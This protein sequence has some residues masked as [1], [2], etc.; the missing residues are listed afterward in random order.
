MKAFRQSGDDDL[1]HWSRVSQSPP[2]PSPPSRHFSSFV[3]QL[4]RGSSD[5]LSILISIIITIITIIPLFP[6]LSIHTHIYIYIYTH[7]YKHMGGLG[8]RC[9]HGLFVCLG[10]NECAEIG[11]WRLVKFGGD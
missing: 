6:S 10:M 3:H 1:H 5:A 11:D 9:S 2:L 8:N 4:W 7:T